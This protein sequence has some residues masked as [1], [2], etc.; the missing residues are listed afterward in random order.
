MPMPPLP[1]DAHAK[2][3]T[4]A[5]ALSRSG[6]KPLFTKLLASNPGAF[7]DIT[8]PP[9]MRRSWLSVPWAEV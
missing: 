7:T 6:A 3:L 5:M 1:M 8:M 9:G 2:F 4:L